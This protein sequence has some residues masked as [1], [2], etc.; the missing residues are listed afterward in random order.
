[1]PGSRSRALVEVTGQFQFRT[2][3]RQFRTPLRTHHRV[4][5]QRQGIIVRLQAPMGQVSFG[6]IAPLPEFGSEPF[7][8]AEQFCRS[9]PVV[10]AETFLQHVPVAYPATRFGLESAWRSLITP[11]VTPPRQRSPSNCC[12]LLPTGSAALSTW[13]PLWQQGFRTFKWKLGVAAWQPEK[14]ALIQLCQALPT[15]A[16]LRLDAN[17]GLNLDT[18]HQLLNLCDRL[19]AGT[20]EF[21]EQPLPPAQF[22]ELL[23]IAQTYR[24]PIALDESVASLEQLHA[25]HA[26]DWPGIYVL[27]ASIL[28]SP[29]E[30]DAL[31]RDANLDVVFSTVFE[32]SIGRQHCLHLAAAIANPNRALGFGTQHWFEDDGL[33]DPDPER[34]WQHLLSN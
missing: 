34:V 33:D 4:W 6:E 1:M 5:Q 32:T 23:A 18:T 10:A 8:A 25:C 15:D 28:G 2:Y 24:T 12:A 13:Q 19:P 22:A 14:Q 11:P 30:L 16:R 31:I 3:C 17:G 21:V 20:I 26:A 27:K 9:L 7:E 29:T